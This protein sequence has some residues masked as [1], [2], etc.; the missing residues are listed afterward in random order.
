MNRYSDHPDI[1]GD[2]VTAA[3]IR[4][5]E[6]DIAAGIG[7]IRT[8]LSDPKTIPRVLTICAYASR[9]GEM[10]FTSTRRQPVFA[11]LYGQIRA[12]ADQ[13]PQAIAV[14][15]LGSSVGSSQSPSLEGVWRI[16]V[17]AAEL[18]TSMLLNGRD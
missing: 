18:A 12:S 10:V 13:D 9:C 8:R 7:G 14:R 5:T 17:R 4:P 16:A 2:E 11:V 1:A 6:A 15:S 3:R